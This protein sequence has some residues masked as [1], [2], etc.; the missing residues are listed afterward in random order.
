MN[1]LKIYKASLNLTLLQIRIM[2]SSVFPNL[3][4]ARSV[5]KIYS[6]ISLLNKKNL[7]ILNTFKSQHCLSW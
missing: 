7:V 5:K 6:L 4:S 1:Y 2:C 3:D